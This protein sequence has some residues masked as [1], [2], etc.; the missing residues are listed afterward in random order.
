MN[1]LELTQQKDSITSEID[2]KLDKAT[3]TM[4]G[5]RM[6]NQ[7]LIK[8]FYENKDYNKNINLEEK[9]KEIKEQL[10]QKNNEKN[11]LIKQLEQH[12]SCK[13]KQKNLEQELN[14]LKTQY[15]K[16]TK[17]IHEI[18][19]KIENSFFGNNKI[20]KSYLTIV[21]KKLITLNKSTPNIYLNQNKKNNNNYNT[22][23]LPLISSKKNQKEKTI[24]STE[25]CNKI[26]EEFK[27]DENE[28]NSLIEKIKIIEKI[29][30]KLRK[31]IKM[32]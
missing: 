20:N 25:F 4:K 29:G 31:K 13:E 8:L 15:K 22:L 5:L 6:E 17:N 23:S 11:L 12:S 9:N 28:Y 26:K 19:E 30:I 21:S 24:L 32:K 10:Q 1:N 7:E 27:E 2:K 3:K 16:I 18:K 14:T